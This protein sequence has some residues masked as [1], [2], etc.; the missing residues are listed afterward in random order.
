MINVVLQAANPESKNIWDDS[1]PS[2]GNYWSDYNGPDQYGGPYQNESG[3]DGIGDI[4]YIIDGANEDRY[5][6]MNTWLHVPGHDI[7]VISVTA[8][9]TVVGQGY[10]LNINVTVI[11]QRDST[12]TFNVTVYANET[13]I[14]TFTDI[15]LTIGAFTTLTFTW[16]TTGFA[17]G[18]YTISACA[19]P[20]P[21]ETD[22]SDNTFVDGWVFVSVPGDINADRKV[23]LKDVYAVGRAF[24]SVR[25]ST[26]G[27]YWHSP[28]KTCCPHSPNCDIND[29]G[30]IDL[31]DYYTTCK[32]FG[33]SW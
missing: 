27:W 25:N 31:K 12:E 10:S 11:N 30:K 6:L 33:K 29:D 17:K 9:K 23:D 20:V 2:G 32:N 24:G 21:G 13:S 28:R 1:Y 16:N 19:T 4:P 7:A 18:N 14:A 26:D 15:I 5:P 8:S 22:T 3:S